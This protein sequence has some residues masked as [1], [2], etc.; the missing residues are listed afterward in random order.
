MRCAHCGHVLGVGHV[1]R[2]GNVSVDEC[3][4]VVFDVDGM[5]ARCE[6]RD[7]DH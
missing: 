1:D 2:Q 4:A 3:Q 5:L 7:F 6:C